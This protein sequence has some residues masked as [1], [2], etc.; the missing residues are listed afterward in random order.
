MLVT[1]TGVPS[2]WKKK[3]EDGISVNP[4]AMSAKANPVSSS[5]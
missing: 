3:Y 4:S 2:K 5:S 1:A